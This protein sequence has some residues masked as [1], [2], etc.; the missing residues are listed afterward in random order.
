MAHLKHALLLTFFVMILSVPLSLGEPDNKNKEEIGP[1]GNLEG[2]QDK[3]P[4]GEGSDFEDENDFKNNAPPE[5]IGDAVANGHLA[6]QDVPK[7]RFPECQS[8]IPENKL[9]NLK[10]GQIKN[11]NFNEDG[12]PSKVSNLGP[13]VTAI[14]PEQASPELVNEMTGE[15]REE[16]DGEQWQNAMEESDQIENLQEGDDEA[17]RQGLAHQGLNGFD[18]L[19]MSDRPTYYE[20]GVLDFEGPNTT[21]QADTFDH[22]DYPHVSG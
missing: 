10:E 16:L 5:K 20:D 2:S 6:A 12:M 3:E 8:Q 19:Y 7:D 14:P 4:W 17:V 18:D 1:G 11:M 13:K 9:G 22:G 15:Q 21:V